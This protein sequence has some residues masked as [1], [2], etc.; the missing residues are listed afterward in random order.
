[1]EKHYNLTSF[2]GIMDGSMVSEMLYKG[3]TMRPIPYPGSIDDTSHFTWEQ[4]I[5]RADS[6]VQFGV[7]CGGGDLT[8]SHV[9]FD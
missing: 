2:P 6:W 4:C 9:S 8:K 7:L 1:M 5:L 3:E